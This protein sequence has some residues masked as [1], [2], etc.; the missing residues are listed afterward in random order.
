MTTGSLLM[1]AKN[2]SVEL[3]GVVECQGKPGYLYLTTARLGWALQVA[4]DF[5][6]VVDFA[7]L[8]AQQV[9]KAG[10]KKVM[11]KVVLNEPV[12]GDAS[13][14][15]IFTS[16]DKA[17][18]ERE[19][20]KEGLIRVLSRQRGL[21]T[22]AHSTS[23][24]SVTSNASALP[25]KSLD[26][27][28]TNSAQMVRRDGAPSPYMISLTPKLFPNLGTV[29]PAPLTRQAIKAR[30]HV[31]S[32][33]PDLAQLHK[34][35][36]QAGYIHE[37]EFWATRKQLLESETAEMEQQKGLSSAWPE[38]LPG[39]QVE[40]SYQYTLSN[41][42]IFSIF[43]KHPKVKQA[44]E[45]TVPHEMAA[46]E[47]WKRFIASKVFH[48]DRSATTN[49][50]VA[51]D[52]FDKCA[53]EEEQ[54]D[55]EQLSK[56]IKLGNLHR[57]LDMSQTEEDHIETGNAPNFSMKAGKLADSQAII[58]SF[59][60]HSQT[61][62]KAHLENTAQL[63]STN[64]DDELVISDLQPETQQPHLLLEIANERRYLESQGLP[65]QETS[66]DRS[67]S[68]E[69]SE[70]ILNQFA[71]QF[72]QANF[73]LYESALG[74]EST[75][76]VLREL[77]SLVRDNAQFQWARNHQSLDLPVELTSSLMSCHIT[78]YEMLRHL[79][80]SLGVPPS[81]EGFK[82]ATKIMDAIQLVNESIRE[83]LQEARS[84]DA[85]TISKVG[86][87]MA[88]LQTAIQTGQEE[89]NRVKARRI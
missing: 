52:L 66:G 40:K 14:T 20:F 36:V 75:T 23:N 59:N 24:P 6:I 35:L 77:W 58:K 56:R 3:K 42:M 45:E 65:S 26:P 21:P 87:I 39:V 1:L 8:K 5:N 30:Q 29:P 76:A 62:L 69:E 38:M 70:L 48:R 41:D 74:K 9:S 53:E 28:S 33:H 25:N 64:L 13:Y 10:S 61:V 27:G 32:K 83:V 15:F 67:L 89:Y 2:E 12:N 86:K 34:D 68:T 19:Q 57:Y 72:Q 55:N 63:A 82:R 37:E 71:H 17:L 88:P 11:L 73:K 18:D 46:E 49:D 50:G 81:E 22:P 44:F 85:E 7:N 31:L 54:E 47:F 51:D 80:A 60:R 4:K 16:P 79:W 78:G 43:Q 84:S